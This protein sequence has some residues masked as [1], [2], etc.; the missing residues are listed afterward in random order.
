MS[1]EKYNAEYLK[2][3]LLFNINKLNDRLETLRR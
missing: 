1:S 3:D 2:I